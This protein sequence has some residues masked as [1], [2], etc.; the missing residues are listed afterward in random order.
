M[1]RPKILLVDDDPDLLR[2]LRLR[3]RAN[4]YEVTTAS[5]GYSAIASAQKERPS[6][7][8][9]DLGLP[10]GDGFVVLDRL[11]NIDALSGVPVIVLSARDPQAN[12][13]RALRAGAAAFFQKPA[14]NDELMN[15]IQVS[16]GPGSAQRAAWPS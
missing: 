9:L 14:D 15:V 10:V 1:P 13:E 5:D 3:L 4:N 6:L 16:L 8:I 11:Q 12:E 7:I 2:A